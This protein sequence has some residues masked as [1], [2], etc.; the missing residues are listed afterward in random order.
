[1][2]L[3]CSTMVPND[4]LDRLF[5]LSSGFYLIAVVSNRI[6]DTKDALFYS[7]DKDSDDSIDEQDSIY[8]TVGI[9]WKTK[10][11]FHDGTESILT[12]TRDTMT[13]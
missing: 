11:V 13:P 7:I 12:S 3:G 10:D 1:M 9:K 2:I 4:I 5:V 6:L 8:G